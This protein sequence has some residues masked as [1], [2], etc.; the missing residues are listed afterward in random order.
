MSLKSQLYK[1][2]RSMP[3][4][5]AGGY[6]DLD[7][8]KLVAMLAVEIYP[9]EKLDRLVGITED[10][11][12]GQ[13]VVMIENIFKKA[14]GRDANSQHFF[15]EIVVTAD[16]MMHIYLR[17]NTNSNHIISFINKNQDNLVL[18]LTKARAEVYKLEAAL[19]A[20][21]ERW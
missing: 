18:S 16:D 17:G 6:I 11:F 5:I 14:R 9:K 1:S 3:S 19:R 21:K 7:Q 13:N 4:C 15:K 2:I 12:Q 20:E 8:G 10:L